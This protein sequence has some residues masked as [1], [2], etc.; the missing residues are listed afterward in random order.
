MPNFGLRF[1][2][3]LQ[4]LIRNKVSVILRIQVQI[5][6]LVAIGYIAAKKGT[7]GV[8]AR[9]DLTNLVIYVFLPCNI[10]SSFASSLTVDL[11]KE[12]GIVL[13]ASFAAQG[14]YLVLNRFLYNRFPIER[15]IV[16]QY[17]TSCNNSGFMGLPVIESVFGELGTLYGSIVLV[18]MRIVMWTA[19]LSLFTKTDK[20]EQLKRLAT[21]PCIWAVIVGVAYLFSPVK[22]PDVLY[23]TITMLSRCVTP[24]SM[25]IVGG[26]LSEVDMKTVFDGAVFYY[27]AL[28]LLVIPAVIFGVLALLGIDPVATGSVVLSSAMP[29]ATTTAML[30]Q[31]YDRDAAFASKLIFVST[32]IS[33]VTLPLIGAFLKHYAG[34]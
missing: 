16:L 26:I 5:F 30:A 9:K 8:A 23:S 24:L 12:C 6:I 19:G 27:S 20:K 2:F 13:I 31:K 34:I 22:L 32:L 33:L 10:F 7:F 29:A 11:L 18:P 17:A 14:F 3:F 21:H 4:L 15:R 28:R 1:D 25:I